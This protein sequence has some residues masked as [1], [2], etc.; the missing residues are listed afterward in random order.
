MALVFAGA[1]DRFAL[2]QQGRAWQAW[3]TAALPRM[4]KFPSLESLMGTKR[5]ARRQTVSEIETILA[6]WA[7]RG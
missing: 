5:T 7:A 4:Q 6:A 1:S 3:H 2:D